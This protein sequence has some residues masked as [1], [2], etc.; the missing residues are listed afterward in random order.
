MS[1]EIGHGMCLPAHI[2]P[3]TQVPEIGRKR[4]N[5]LPACGCEGKTAMHERAT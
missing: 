1:Q 5:A 4:I 2:R 3:L